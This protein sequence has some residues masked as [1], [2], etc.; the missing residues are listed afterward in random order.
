M[1]QSPFSKR[2]STLWQTLGPGFITGA[3]DD[4]PSGIATYT[5]TGALFGFTQLWTALF[6]LPFTIIIQ[7]ICGRIGMVTGSG[8]SRIIKKHY[9][10]SALYLCVGLLALA[11]TINIGANLGA[12]AEATQLLLPI[13]FTAGLLLYTVLLVCMQL[14]SSYRAYV[15]ILKYLTLSLL[16]YIAVAFIARVNWL[17][18]WYGLITPQ[19]QWTSDYLFNI[20]AILGTTLSPYLFFWQTSEEV[21]EAVLKRKIKQ[22]G[23]LIKR[24]TGSEIQHMRTDTI[25]GMGFSNMI[26]FFIILSAASTLHPAGIRFIETA[27]Q[28]ALALEPIAGQF[29]SFIFTLGIVG[30]GLLSVPILAGS[31]SY[32]VAELFGWREGLYKSP[33]KAP[34]FYGTIAGACVL[35]L[36][37]NF[38]TIKPFVMLYYTAVLNG[39]CAPIILVYIMK[40]ANN[41]AIMG[42]HTNSVVSNFFGWGIALIMGLAAFAL[43]IQ[44]LL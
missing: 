33:R 8:L 7:E 37:I 25:L 22:M 40:I 32:A 44:L 36:L 3:S 9:S 34:G 13:P 26:M 19:I 5:Q 20:V 43:V 17:T 39:V 38:T 10:R 21:E 18:V 6:T 12:M 35:G 1:A 41:S 4:D 42:K 28:A 30:S 11:N 23:W 16:A 27:P 24:V 29:A 14:F 2:L 31:A 15:Q